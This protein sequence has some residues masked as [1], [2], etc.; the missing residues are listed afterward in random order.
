[1]AQI[2]SLERSS[3]FDKLPGE[4]F[5]RLR[6]LVESN[7]IPFSISTTWRKVRSGDFPSPVKV[8]SGVTAWR[9]QDIRAWLADPSG[10]QER[11]C[12]DVRAPRSRKEAA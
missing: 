7:L 2:F 11:C 10:Y 3:D 6:Q 12:T 8:S 1:M 9:V 4:A 5:I